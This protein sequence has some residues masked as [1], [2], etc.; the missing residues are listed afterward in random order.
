MSPKWTKKAHFG[1]ISYNP[2][3]YNAAIFVVTVQYNALQCVEMISIK[4]QWPQY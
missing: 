3:Y 1:D 4:G 2:Y